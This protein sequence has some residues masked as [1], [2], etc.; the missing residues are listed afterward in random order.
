[1]TFLRGGTGT[2]PVIHVS[3]T[4]NGQ[5]HAVDVPDRMSLADHLCALGSPINVGCET[6]A[7]NSCLV[8]L[9]GKLVASC[10][11]FAAQAH[12]CDITT[13]HGLDAGDG[14]TAGQLALSEQSG[15]QCGFCTPAFA[16]CLTEA[17]HHDMA[18][19]NF[20]A[21]ILCRCTG[22]LGQIRALEQ[23][24]SGSSHRRV[25]FMR[26]REDV[27]LVTGRGTFPSHRW[28]AG[29]AW[30]RVI[31]SPHALARI[32]RIDSMQA[33]QMPGVLTVLTATDLP[34]SAR[35][36]H[37]ELEAQPSTIME[38]TLAI[39]EVRYVGQP[40]AVVVGETAEQ[41]EDAA[42][43]VQIEYI[44][45]APVTDVVEGASDLWDGVQRVGRYQPGPDDVVVQSRFR[46]SR[47]TGMPLEPRALSAEWHPGSE[48]LTV[49]GV[50]KHPQANRDRLAARLDVDPVRIRMP[51][52]DV[53]GSFGVK[54]EF[55][56][57]DV[58]V[59]YAA[60][61]LRRPVKWVEDRSE[62]MVAT[63]HSREQMWDVEMA[64]H[65]DGTLTGARVSI[66]SDSGAYLRPLTRLTP[67][68]GSAMFP[69]PYRLPA[70]EA[71]VRP[72]F[73]NKTPIGTYRAPGRFEANFVRERVLD[74]MA[75]RLGI[76]PVHLRMRNLLTG[77]E[78][79]YD[80]GTRN[81]GPVRYDVGEFRGAFEH[82]ANT[83]A[84]WGANTS[85]GMRVGSAVVPFVEKAGLGPTETAEV[86]L[87]DRGRLHV[88]TASSPSGQGHETAF[89]SIVQRVLD[90]PADLID[91]F[92]GDAGGRASGPGSFASRGVM[93]TGSAVH[94]AACTLRDR[95]LGFAAAQAGRTPDQVSPCNGV[96]RI[97]SHLLDLAEL[98][99]E[100]RTAIGRFDC[101]KHSY[102]YGAV[103]C[104]VD[105][106]PELFTL[107]VGRL[108]IFCDAGQVVDPDSARG[109]LIGGAV[110]GIGGALYEQLVY[111]ADGSPLVLQ[112]GDYLLPRASDVHS[113][114][115][116]LLKPLPTISNPLGAKGVGEAGIAAIGAVVANA[117]CA[118][119]PVLTDLLT[120]L[121][122]TPSLLHRLLTTAAELD[123]LDAAHQRT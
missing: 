73:T 57:E 99:A 74:M 23:V 37:T 96:V 123:H 20:L 71:A 119:L 25:D 43:A 92:C 7:C 106:D 100:Q 33:R 18:P 49:W 81:E 29:Q 85:T 19:A 98:A 70:F 110:Q 104:Q 61:T 91:V 93:M 102:P 94:V 30:L 31:R 22:Y 80:T 41:A 2:E 63:N 27:R 36:L 109:Q 16:L 28:L 34:V 3:C 12:G 78:M 107:R 118:A 97:G 115:A 113:V 1:M 62:H 65:R 39:D 35:Y 46:V 44:R 17:G 58:L 120:E 45:C 112:L 10:L 32:C 40:V 75:S 56:P 42:C 88:Y 48:V 108:E 68:L 86:V 4:V 111:A 79:P 55:Y 5:R 121:P 82:A 103:A 15:L 117:V 8:R 9:D 50:C 21:P 53:G 69:G 47:H 77:A 72:S 51:A 95:L 114:V 66:I 87:T 116:T 122:V 6:G 52:G 76:D 54:G 13:V 24:R 101:D 83:A 105:V 26:R 59:P 89:A 11:L 90:V 38:P 67:Y 64:A 14:L 60:L 84:S